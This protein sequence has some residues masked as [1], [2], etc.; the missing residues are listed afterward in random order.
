MKTK[1][2]KKPWIA[3]PGSTVQQNYAEDLVHGYLFWDIGSRDDF[4]VEFCPL[5]N[6]KPFVTIEWKGTVADTVK[7]S[8][9]YPRGTRFRIRSRDHISQKDMVNLTQELRLHAAAT[10]VTY[11]IDQ[12]VSRDT[13]SSGDVTLVKD[14]LRNPDVL[15]KLFRDYYKD[16]QLSP[17]EW[18][19]ADELVKTYLRTGTGGDDVTRNTKWSL[20]HLK[21]DNMFS[22]GE[23]NVINFEKLQGITGVFGPN[24]IGKSSI[25]GTVMYTLFNATDR[26]SLKNLH[27]INVRK[28]FCNARFVIGV[29]GTDYVIERQTVRY[30]TKQLEH[31]VTSLNLF[32]LDGDTLIDLN[33]E[34]RNDTDKAVRKL[35][36]T[37]DDCLLTCVSTQGDINR[38]IDQGSTQRKLHVAKYLDVDIFD[39]MYDPA[40][41]DL[42]ALKGA[43]KNHP[44]RDWQG[45]IDAS[46]KRL[47]ALEQDI[48]KNTSDLHEAVAGVDALKAKLN[49]HRDF[50]PV[51]QSQVDALRSRFDT[52]MSQH[53]SL[54]ASVATLKETTCDLTEKV[55]RIEA[56]Q[57]NYDITAM[58]KQ[59]AAFRKLESAVSTL[60]SKHNHELTVLKQQDRSLKI[61]DD[62]PC[63]DKYPSCKFIKDAHAVKPK[64]ESQREKTERA[65]EKLN[66]AA[67]ALGDA[68]G[69]KLQEQIDKY[70]QLTHRL[71]TMRAE[72]SAKV[73][74]L[75]RLEAKV[76]PGERVLA[77]ERGRLEDLEQALKNE[78]NAEVVSLR[79]EIDAATATVRRLDAEKLRKATE[80]GKLQSEIEQCRRSMTAVNE[81]LGKL[82]V[83]ELVANAFS[84]RGIPSNV[85]NSQL[86]LI[87]SEIAKILSGIVDF[88]VELETEQ[89]GNALDVY[90]NYGDSRRV[91]ELASGMEK[92]IS[93]LAIRVALSNVS[94]LPKTDTLIIDEGFG[95]LDDAG[96][97]A[98][99]RLL[100][101]LKRYFRTIIII[102]HVDGIKDV[103]DTIV[104]ISKNEK[105]ARVF[106]E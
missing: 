80:R 42:N 16:V 106:F 102:S 19:T 78:E 44:D 57:E 67:T 98:C 93:S 28:P 11:K 37:S 53:T 27:V 40:K 81:L 94:S 48:E 9:A 46:E 1:T 45:T 51:T 29:D 66:E 4:S 58:R 35:I 91:I 54:V 17:D 2:V 13:I 99:N 83:H 104:E 61:L 59:L 15:V 68:S 41:N 89:D 64:V 105:D 52:M 62:V 39:K 49:S 77:E 55:K 23:G 95:V 34:Q 26:G 100:V 47:Q 7:A 31:A 79:R 63:G 14:D 50:T 22:F 24:R 12:Q 84:K 88:T 103:A 32:K 25:V 56:V 8:S 76:E 72:H 69:D 73:V 21:F 36:G 5:P 70:D 87:N 90:I 92:M 82:K 18:A 71:A 38:F 74:E 10:E 3:Y 30:E 6:P 65:L 96:V 101:A 20:K 33:G 97:E 85:I 60:K 43:L 86:P 75:A